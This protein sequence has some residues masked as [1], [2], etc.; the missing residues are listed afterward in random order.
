MKKALLLA[1]SLAASAPLPSL[2]DEN[3]ALRRCLATEM[4]TGRYRSSDPQAPYRMLDACAALWQEARLRVMREKDINAQ[5]ADYYMAMT[6]HDS[7]QR[8][9]F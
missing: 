5:T 7:L 3:D 4:A 1:A 8:S 9:G 6:L 2:A